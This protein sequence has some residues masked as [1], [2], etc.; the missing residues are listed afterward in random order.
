MAKILAKEQVISNV[1]NDVEG[2]FGIIQETFKKAKQQNPE[3][4]LDEVRQSGW[5]FG[6]FFHF[7]IYLE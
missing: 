6:T 3:I 2:F 1:Y 4:T 7:P 5:W